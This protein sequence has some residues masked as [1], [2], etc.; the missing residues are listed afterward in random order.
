VSKLSEKHLLALT[1]GVTLFLAGGLGFLIWSDFQAIEEEERL[2]A[3]LRERIR[4]AEVEIAQV[5]ARE[6]RVIANREIADKE[7]TFLPEETEIE[8][9]WENV[10]RMADESGVQI[11]RISPR[12]TASSS[13]RTKKTSTSIETVDQVLSLRGSSDELLRFFN[14]VENYDRIITIVEFAITPGRA[15]EEDGKMRHSVN[16]G[17]RT[18]TYS[19]KIANTIVSI[20]DYEKKR[21]LIEVKQ[22]LS[23]IKLEEKESYTLRP[24]INRRDP[25]VDV[26]HERR[27]PTA[28]VPDEQ[29]RKHQELILLNLVDQVRLLQEQLDVEDHLRAIKDFFRLGA[30]MKQNREAFRALQGNLETTEKSRLLTFPDLLEQFRA[31]VQA[32]FAQIRERIGFIDTQRD[33][34]EVSQ[35]QE[36]TNKLRS[37]FDERDW[38]P[39]AE[40]L[41]EW[42]AVS[43]N[44]ENVVEEAR[45]LADE[46]AELGRRAGVIQEFD[47]RKIAISSIVFNSG[48]TSLAY[49]NKKLMGEGDALDG[50]GRVI[51]YEIGE[52]FVIFL[53]EGVEIKRPLS[54]N[55]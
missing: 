46:V 35:V 26:R 25:F 21:E 3:D 37:A 45:L 30:V 13:S 5:P 12:A 33:L 47:K 1:I 16:L 22:W 9:F 42:N 20:K 29:D 38:K 50:D 24:A 23:R 41:R 49:I 11:S 53:T 55:R 51:V 15:A 2:T 52:N 48:G 43:K 44:G 19:R 28:A 8:T 14:L 4:A 40:L 18:F 32:P 6:A 17:L 36:W 39:F 34:L 54:M 27:D 7:V 10:E 31:E